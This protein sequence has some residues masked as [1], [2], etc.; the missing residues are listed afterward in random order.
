M[1]HTSLRD[2]LT[3]ETQSKV[4][5]VSPSYHLNLTYRCFSLN[6]ERELSGAPWLPNYFTEN[7]GYHWSD[8]LATIPGKSIHAGLQ[9]LSHLP[10]RDLSYHLLS[11][12]QAFF[13]LFDPRSD[14]AP[15]QAMDLFI[16]CTESLVLALEC[17]PAPGRWLHRGFLYSG[18]YTSGTGYA[19]SV[20]CSEIQHEHATILQRNVKRAET[21]IRAKVL[22]ASF[23]LQH[24][25]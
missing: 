20:H 22:C 8:F 10:D 4:F 12:I 21:A 7:C 14:Y 1:C 24:S 11:L 18:L 19:L 3:N 2:F 16:S 15:I 17:D 23:A 25:F 5:F 13:C 9:Q 6:L